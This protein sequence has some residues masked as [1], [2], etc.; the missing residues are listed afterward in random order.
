L[1]EWN[2]DLLQ[3][4]LQKIVLK[5]NATARERFA[6]ALFAEAAK[7]DN[8]TQFV[9]E[10]TEVIEMPDFNEQ[11]MG[12]PNSIDLGP[13][14]RSQL[15][16]Y[17]ACMASL[18]RANPFHNFE[19]ACHVA[20]SA[21]K[22][23]KR[24]IAP[25]CVEYKAESG[26]K[27]KSEKAVSR[28]IH[29]TTFGISSDPLMQFAAVFSALIHDVDHTGLTNKQ[30]VQEDD[31]LAIKYRGKCVAEQ[32]SI[33]VAWDTLMQDTFVELRRCIYKTEE[34][35]KR[36]RQ[37]LVNA[38]IAT[39]IADKELNTWRKNRWDKVFHQEPSD[40]EITSDR[41][42][43]IVFEYIIQASDVAHT[44]Q[45]WHIYQ[46]WNKRLFDERYAAYL[47]GRE[48][49]D[50]SI[51]WHKGEIWFF[52]NY[53]IP[54]AK[55]LEECHVFGVSCDEYLT[56]ALENRHEWE[57]KGEEIVEELVSHHHH[58]IKN[59]HDE[60]ILVTPRTLLLQ[61]DPLY[62]SAGSLL[63]SR[64]PKRENAGVA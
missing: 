41:K 10:I 21:S 24:I 34:E 62:G 45:H 56:Y 28:E 33:Q 2:A 14:V 8:N 16:E 1:V 36:F 58:E 32:R 29:Q 51:S 46:K 27:M 42:A 30:L 31:L 3:G 40:L 53:V 57:L 25:D 55:K 50:P 47:A 63:S 15:R 37:L 60:D 26:N 43:T 38:V 6:K 54:L 35:K 22:L 18:Y 4:L 59:N 48:P 20:M 61:K 7:G 11:V 19:H 49:D 13:A 5:R 64:E 17:V 9:D 12:D 23:L 39:D 44:M 52:D